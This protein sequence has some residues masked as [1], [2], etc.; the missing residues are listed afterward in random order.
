METDLAERL[1]T[2]PLVAQ[3]LLNRGV[4]EFQDCQDFLRPS[5]NCLHGPFG[6]PN[7]RKAA[8]RIAVRWFAA[9]SVSYSGSVTDT[10][11]SAM[12]WLDS[13]RRS[14]SCCK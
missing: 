11:A 9:S 12:R 6:I 10:R 13:M 5:L 14:Q 7:L 8:E 4:S 3:V 2:S 1:K